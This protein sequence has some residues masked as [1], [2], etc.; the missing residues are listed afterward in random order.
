VIGSG[1]IV[2]PGEYALLPARYALIPDSYLVEFQTGSSFR[3]LRLGQSV[4]LP[5]GSNAVA[6]IR[7]AVGTS[8]SDSQTIGAV[9]RPGVETRQASDYNIS[10]SQFFADAAARSRIAVPPQ[11][12]DAGRLI[13]SRA[14]TLAF[15][16]TFETSAAVGVDGSSGKTAQF[17]I[18]APKI[19]IV[20]E[21]GN[22]GFAA[23]YLQIASSSLSSLRGSVLL[24]GTRASTDSGVRISA[25]AENL[26]VANNAESPVQVP[27]LLLTALDTIDVREGAVLSASGGSNDGNSLAM[28]ADAGG[29]LVRLSS[30]AQATVSRGTTPDLTRGQVLIGEGAVLTGAKSVLVDST[31]TTKS[32]GLIS[33]SCSPIVRKPDSTLSPGRTTSRASTSPEPTLGK[34]TW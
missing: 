6:A 26:V 32:R 34:T 10:G 14:S 27:E 29:A 2:P 12:L 9:I 5:N 19:A 24:G 25:A 1:A 17:D 13:I 21:V 15:D 8:V 3:N 20:D 7:H 4:A 23:D 22:G 30:A 33:P 18:S 28:F 16:G 11:P 31:K